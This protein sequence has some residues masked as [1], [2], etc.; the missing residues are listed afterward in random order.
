VEIRLLVCGNRGGGFVIRP[1][2]STIYILLIS[3]SGYLLLET[4]NDSSVFLVGLHMVVCSQ[5][6]LPT[7]GMGDVK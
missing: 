4:S 6:L 1:S 2:F 3:G 5:L 7:T